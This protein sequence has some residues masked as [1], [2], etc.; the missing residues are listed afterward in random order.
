MSFD[1]AAEADLWQAPLPHLVSIAGNVLNGRWNILLSQD[2]GVSVA[3]LNVLL[4]LSRGEGTHSEIARRCWVHVS[5][6]T[7]IVDT[8]ER[9]HLVERV[10]DTVDRRKVM[11]VLTPEGTQ[12]TERMASIMRSMP[13]LTPPPLTS[14]HEAII[15]KFLIETI[16]LDEQERTRGRAASAGRGGAQ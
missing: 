15:R 1:E 7:G 9:D 3:G 14:E 2:H 16:L 10:R 11:L 12:V 6:L 8:L 4:A 5:T 13:P